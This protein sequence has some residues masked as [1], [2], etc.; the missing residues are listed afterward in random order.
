MKVW[1]GNER[2]GV[3]C[4]VKTLFVGSNEVKFKRIK[5]LIDEH[6]VR[7]IYF[8]AGKCTPINYKVV[9]KCLS[10]LNIY[11]TA[12][13]SIDKLNDVPNDVIKF[14]QLIITVNH[15]NFKLLN[16]TNKMATQIKLQAGEGKDKLIIT[17]LSYFEETDTKHLKGKIYK[18]DEVIE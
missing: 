14:L 6:N 17:P 11:V 16:N 18:G 1:V 15:K 12:E 2:E 8:G 3:F 10:T 9:R 4:G 13:V 5:E 7:Q